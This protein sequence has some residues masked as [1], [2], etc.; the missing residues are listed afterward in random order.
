MIIDHLTYV[1]SVA[2]PLNESDAGVDF[3]LVKKPR[4]FFVYNAVLTL[5]SRNL[6]KKGSEVSIGTRSTL[7]L[8]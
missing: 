3:V 5:S 7:G 1:C 6:Y 8:L 4:P 2:W